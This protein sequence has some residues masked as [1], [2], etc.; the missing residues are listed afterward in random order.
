MEQQQQ[1]EWCELRSNTWQDLRQREHI[2]RSNH[3]PL[4]QY[5]VMPSFTD[6]W[7]IDF[8]RSG[9]T[10]AAYHTVWR[11]TQDIEA[12]ATAIERLKHPNPFL[13]TLESTQI[14]LPASTIDNVLCQIAEIPI[15]LAPIS[16]SISLDGTLFE[17]QV[18]DGWTGIRLQWHNRLPDEWAALRPVLTELDAMERQASRHA[19]EDN[20]APEPR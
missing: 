1:Q 15:R 11:M 13:P 17:L 18:G 3:R 2:L 20:D 8:V 12:F 7:C 4:L 6:S 16:N 14:D 10:L 19:F 9:D 5:L